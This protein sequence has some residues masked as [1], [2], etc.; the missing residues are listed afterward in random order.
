ML[1]KAQTCHVNIV[2]KSQT[3]FLNQRNAYDIIDALL[4]I[5]VC[6]NMHKV[7]IHHCLHMHL[8]KDADAGE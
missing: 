3:H 8:I 4:I 2:N 6:L 7:L 5:F 1:H